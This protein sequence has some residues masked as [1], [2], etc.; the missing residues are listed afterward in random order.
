MLNIWE[1]YMKYIKIIYKII[2]SC[3]FLIIHCIG[4]GVTD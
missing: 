3:Q 4:N 2:M 1:N